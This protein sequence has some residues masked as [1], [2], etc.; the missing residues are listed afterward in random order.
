MRKRYRCT[1]CGTTH[2]AGWDA[3]AVWDEHAQAAVLGAVMDQAWCGDCGETTLACEE[4]VPASGDP[5]I[6]RSDATYVRNDLEAA[7]ILWE[8]YLDPESNA[9][10]PR[11]FNDLR[12]EIG[13]QEFRQKLLNLVGPLQSV[14]EQICAEGLE[15]GMAPFDW[16]FA[17][18][19]LMRC[20]VV[21]D[22][23]SP[24]RAE[25]QPATIEMMRPIAEA[26]LP[27]GPMAP[28]EADAA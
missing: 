5:S 9:V 8:S 22:L 19:F 1:K 4:I 14:W 12:D 18:T 23:A 7:M 13:T 2:S 21:R 26:H 17:P 27:G 15:G 3:H 11:A 28:E 16:N 25:I 24:F 20:A 6:V 10:L